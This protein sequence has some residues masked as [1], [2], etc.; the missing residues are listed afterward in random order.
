MEE[1][2]EKILKI[3]NMAEEIVETARQNQ[4]NIDADVEKEGEALREKL[5]R[6]IEQKRAAVRSE[7]E[8]RAA[9]KLAELEKH[10][11]EKSAHLE[12]SYADKGDVWVNGMFN[13]IINS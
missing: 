3:E 4:D 10:F 1:V 13:N 2:I 11:K 8:Q 5:R 7:E 6:E 12:S 9:G